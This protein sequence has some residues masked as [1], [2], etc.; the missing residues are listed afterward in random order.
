MA[1]RK[2]TKLLLEHIDQL[3]IKPKNGRQS[4]KEIDKMLEQIYYTKEKLCESVKEIDEIVNGVNN[5]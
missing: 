4:M 3:K 5:A 2:M 1:M